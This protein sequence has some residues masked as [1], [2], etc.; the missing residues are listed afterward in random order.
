MLAHAAV[1]GPTSANPLCQDCCCTGSGRASASSSLPD[2]GG[3]GD[4][5]INAVLCVLGRQTRLEGAEINK[6]LLALKECI[7]ALDNNQGH[8]PFRG[9]KLTEVQRMPCC[10]TARCAS[11]GHRQ[12]PGR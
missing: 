12:Q 8:I 10:I 5:D 1:S 11:W 7:R 4:D 9:S 2:A 6:S 3:L